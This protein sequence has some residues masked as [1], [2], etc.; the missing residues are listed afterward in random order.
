MDCESNDG[1]FA[2]CRRFFSSY[3]RQHRLNAVR[4]GRNWVLGR[5][6][7]KNNEG[8]GTTKM[9]VRA[10]TVSG[11]AVP[12]PMQSQVAGP[13]PVLS[14]VH[15]RLRQALK[16]KAQRASRIRS[17]VLHIR[18]APAPLASALPS[19]FSY[20]SVRTQRSLLSAPSS[21]SI[22]GPTCRSDP[23]RAVLWRVPP[24]PLLPLH[25][26]L[27]WLRHDA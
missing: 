15:N 10:H 27:H 24:R 1:A 2:P 23:P 18:R 3:A 8:K 19:V 13:E 12:C 11:S 9:R 22:L 26:R 6:A 7:R 17:T 20:P 21:I 25:A 5:C 16:L 4:L 14:T